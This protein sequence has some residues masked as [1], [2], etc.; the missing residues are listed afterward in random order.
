MCD[1][2]GV[3]SKHVSKFLGRVC[4]TLT[5]FEESPEWLSQDRAATGAVPSAWLWLLSFVSPCEGSKLQAGLT[6]LPDTVLV[7]VVPPPVPQGRCHSLLKNLK[8]GVQAF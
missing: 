6:V 5:E 4:P 1:T 7:K 8:S 2:R 3:I